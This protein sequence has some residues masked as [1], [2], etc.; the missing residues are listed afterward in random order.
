[1]RTR[2][3]TLPLLAVLLTG[4][5]GTRLLPDNPLL[6]SSRFQPPVEGLVG[7]ALLGTAAYF[8]VDPLAPNWEVKASRLDTSRIEIALRQKRFTTGG[9]GE[10]QAL[11]RRHARKFADDNGAGGYEIVSF[12]ESIDSETTLARRVSRGVIRLLPP[13]ASSENRA[14]PDVPA[15]MLPRSG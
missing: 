3:L 15:R 4:C 14:A 5:A 9:D 2:T 6:I 11:F 12:E 10:S 1:M 13:T 7:A 8:I